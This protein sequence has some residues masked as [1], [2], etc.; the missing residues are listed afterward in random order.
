MKFSTFIELHEKGNLA[1][2]LGLRAEIDS[3]GS[4]VVTDTDMKK[5]GDSNIPNS[6]AL[7]KGVLDGLGLGME[8]I[9]QTKTLENNSSSI[10][11]INGFA[12]EAVWLSEDGPMSEE[13]YS[14]KDG[15][16]KLKKIVDAFKDEG[17]KIISTGS[18][19]PGSKTIIEFKDYFNINLNPIVVNS[20]IDGSGFD[21]TYLAIEVK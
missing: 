8:K 6:A 3:N 7:I 18:I 15:I 4:T 10:Y 16:A 21:R 20:A 2:E 1:D 13:G 14:E 17:G 5:E 11:K 19:K 12:V 9:R